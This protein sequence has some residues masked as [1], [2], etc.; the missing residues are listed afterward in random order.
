[1]VHSFG[2]LKSLRLGCHSS[3]SSKIRL[4]VTAVQ[5]GGSVSRVKGQVITFK[6]PCLETYFHQVGPTS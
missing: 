6:S 3:E 1:M 2:E 4:Y 5:A